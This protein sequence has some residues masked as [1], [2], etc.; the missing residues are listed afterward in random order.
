MGE[1]PHRSYVLFSYVEG[2]DGRLAKAMRKYKIKVVPTTTTLFR[3]ILVVGTFVHKHASYECGSRR[4]CRHIRA[5]LRNIKRRVCGFALPAELVSCL[6]P[7]V[8]YKK[9]KPSP[10]VSG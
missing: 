2:L 7:R 6:H 9:D 10:L 4:H 8:N 1:L 5:I 3:G